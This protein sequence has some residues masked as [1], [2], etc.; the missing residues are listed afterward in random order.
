MAKAA[1]SIRSA[2]TRRKS[3][4]PSPRWLGGPQRYMRR[5]MRRV[6]PFSVVLVGCRSHVAP[7]SPHRSGRGVRHGLIRTRRF[8]RTGRGCSSRRRHR[9]SCGVG[10]AGP[11]LAAEPPAAFSCWPR[12]LLCSSGFL[13]LPPARSCLASVFPRSHFW[14]RRGCVILRCCATFCRPHSQNSRPCWLLRQ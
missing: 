8:P 14:L 2:G 6:A 4:S 12:V 11:V 13:S 9:G 7:R 5:L 3:A 10:A 1:S